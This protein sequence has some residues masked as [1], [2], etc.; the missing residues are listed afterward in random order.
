METISKINEKGT[1]C[2]SLAI[3]NLKTRERDQ[4]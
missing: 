3:A 4:K 1:Y 2:I